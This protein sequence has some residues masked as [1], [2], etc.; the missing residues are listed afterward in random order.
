V[1]SP[2]LILASG[3]PRRLAVLRQLGLDPLVHS[4][5]VDESYLEGETAADHVERLARAK[6]EAIAPG[7][8]GALVIGGDTVVLDGERVLFK[9][10]DEEEA[11]RTLLGLAGGCHSVLSG[12]ALVG[13]H[14]T[15]SGVSRAEVRMC[16]FGPEEARLYARTGEPLDKAGAYGIQG[17]G[18]ALVA[19]IEGDYYSVMGFPVAVFIEL[20]GRAG[21][22]YDFGSLTPSR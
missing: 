8:P 14:G 15:E 13:P 16:D 22:R 19:S 11:V 9:P 17:L 18:A 21:W 20:L 3:S 1:R 12:L 7:F 6:A 2:E 5:D 4:A 10:A